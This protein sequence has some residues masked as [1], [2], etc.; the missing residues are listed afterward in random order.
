[1]V[2]FEIQNFSWVLDIS[3]LIFIVQLAKRPPSFY[4]KS[5]GSRRRRCQRQN[6]LRL[7][8]QMITWLPWSYLS[9]SQNPAKAGNKQT[10]NKIGRHFTLKSCHHWNKESKMG[11]QLLTL[12]CILYGRAVSCDK[13]DNLAPKVQRR[14]YLSKISSIFVFGHFNIIFKFHVFISNI[15]SEHIDLSIT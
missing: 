13:C 1:M 3:N 9:F 14:L 7:V 15:F 12:Y 4:N 8:A 11:F 6:F 10:L 2:H 5:S